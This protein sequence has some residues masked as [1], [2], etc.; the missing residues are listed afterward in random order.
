MTTIFFRKIFFQTV[1]YEGDQVVPL[2]AVYL[3]S[4]LAIGTTA[5]GDLSQ[6][7][8]RQ[9]HPIK[10]VPLSTITHSYTDRM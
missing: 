10:T 3:P 8:S 7:R 1:P 4:A 6:V 2:P 9:L 5:C